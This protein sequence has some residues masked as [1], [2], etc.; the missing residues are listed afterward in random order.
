MSGT[1]ENTSAAGPVVMVELLG[2]LIDDQGAIAA[3]IAAPLQRASVELRPGALDQVAGMAPVHALKT[4]IEGHGRF[5]L[6]EELEDLTLAAEQGIAAW[7]S[8]GRLRSPEGALDGWR[9]LAASGATLT[10]LSSIP[11]DLAHRAAERMGLVVHENEWLIASD[12]LGAPRPDRLNERI[13]GAGSV[14]L[15]GSIGAALAVA[16][17]GCRAIIAV[18]R[19]PGAAMLADVT[20]PALEGPGSP[21]WQELVA[22]S[23]GPGSESVV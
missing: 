15:V 14:A 10:V 7:A 1:T 13:D 4:L 17:T 19:S 20:V 8:S 18:G 9:H 11:G 12:E 21:L 3:A 23:A 2:P 5:E 6:L 16:A 22:R